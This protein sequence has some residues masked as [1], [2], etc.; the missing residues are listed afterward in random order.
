MALARKC[1]KIIFMKPSQCPLCKSDEGFVLREDCGD[2]KFYGCRKCGMEFADPMKGGSEEFYEKSYGGATAAEY[3]KNNWEFGEFLRDAERLGAGG[4]LIEAGC[5]PGHFLKLAEEKGF[6]V[7]G[8]DFYKP[9]VDYA[10]EHGLK[11]VKVADIADL[12]SAF[13]AVEF[14]IA[15]LFSVLEH[16]ED[17]AGTLELVRRILSPEGMVIAVVPNSERTS[18]RLNFRK[19]RDGWDYPPHHL[20]RWN[21]KSLRNFFTKA[22]FNVLKVESEPIK[23]LRESFY[24]TVGVIQLLTSTSLIFRVKGRIA[25]ERE[26]STKK[27]VNQKIIRTL[28]LF[29]K[30]FVFAV[31]FLIAPVTFVVAQFL[32]IKGAN[33]YVL[34]KRAG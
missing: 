2:Y 19:K 9:A 15:V 27:S 23:S 8:I 24:F 4:K 33:L 10:I 11:N 29:K 16:F 31:A 28:S 17:P 14:D 30:L 34:A 3:G 12:A 5:G 25:E 1:D 13:P 18:L 6:E 7:Y 21:S 20:T 26:L 32:H 22:G